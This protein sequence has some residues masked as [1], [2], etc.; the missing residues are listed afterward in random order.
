MRVPGSLR[1]SGWIM[2]PLFGVF[3]PTALSFGQAPPNPIRLEQPTTPGSGVPPASPPPPAQVAPPLP[4]PPTYLPGTAP[5]PAAPVPQSVRPARVG[6]ILI[7]GNQWTKEYVIRRQL[8]FL[9]GQILSLPDVRVAERN[10]ARLG[11]FEMNPQTGVRPTVT[12]PDLE[13][14]KELKTILVQV[15]ETQTA[16][17]LFG[18]DVNSDYGLNGTFVYNERNFDILGWPSSFEELISGRAFR[19]GGQELRVELVPGT[20]EQ[21]YLVSFREPYLFDSLF[22]FQASGY[23]TE[24]DFRE[25][26]ESRLGTRLTVGRPIGDCWRVEGTVRLEDV[27]VHHVDFGEP[28]EITR[29]IGDHFLAGFRI[30]AR[31]DTRDSYLRPTSGSLVDMSVEAVTGDY[32]FPKILVDASQYWTTYQRRDGSGKHVVALRSDLGYE[33]SDAPVFERFYAGGFRSMRGFEFRGVSPNVQG[34]EVGG[35]F[36]WLNS[37]EYQVPILSNDHLYG[38]VFLDTGTVEPSV[39]LKDYRVA[40]GFGVR[41]SLPLLGPVPIALDFGFPLHKAPGDHEQV[42]SFWLGFFH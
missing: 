14:D 6:D 26:H 1:V 40:A 21:R 20:D 11:I 15:Q 16:A 34:V 42:F 41:Y 19:G 22:F 2:L 38:V 13:E 9:P 18:V 33:T 30:A 27:G 8:P 3:A 37:V 17:F 35:D 7:Q 29:D 5:A 23:F 39:E 4:P 36:M 25:Y 12:I 10:L 28:V 24:N 31:Y 32:N